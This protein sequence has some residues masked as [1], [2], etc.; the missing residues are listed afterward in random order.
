MDITLIQE[1]TAPTKD[2]QIK[3]HASSI[4]SPLR[5][6]PA[7]RRR[8]IRVLC[9]LAARTAQVWHIFSGGRERLARKHYKTLSRTCNQAKS[10]GKFFRVRQANVE[11]RNSG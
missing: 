10:F 5:G 1:D 6:F 2:K 8:R 4:R 9:L 11:F 3:R 7:A